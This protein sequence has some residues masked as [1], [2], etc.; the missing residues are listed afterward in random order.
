MVIVTM[1]G[2]LGNQLFQ[3]AFGRAISIKRNEPL[4]LDTSWFVSNARSGRTYQLDRFKALD[5]KLSVEELKE[6]KSLLPAQSSHQVGTQ[7]YFNQHS[8]NGKEFLSLKSLFPTSKLFR[9]SQYHFDSNVAESK[10]VWFEG[11][12][13]SEKYFK[14]ISSII[15]EEFTL[16]VALSSRSQSIYNQIMQANNAVSVHIRRGDGIHNSD[17]R[18]VHVC[19]ELPYFQHCIMKMFTLVNRPHFF[20]FTDD[21]HWVWQNIGKLMPPYQFKQFLFTVVDCNTEQEAFADL[22]LMG[23]CRHHIMAASTFS[24]WGAWLAGQ[25]FRKSF[26]VLTPSRWYVPDS[27][28][29]KDLLLPEWRQV[30]G[31]SN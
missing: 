30:D 28:D 20:I 9:E 16:S 18:K 27:F 7:Y 21:K 17:S 8:T 19:V 31:F 29:I 6:V 26:V 23:N 2:G 4:R 14:D 13:Q 12:W 1:M 5:F 15:A 11:Y 24:W 10:A 3:Y 22:Q 25:R